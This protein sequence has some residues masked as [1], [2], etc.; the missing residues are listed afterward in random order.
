M[1][2]AYLQFQ[3]VLNDTEAN[4]K[5]IAELTGKI[6]ENIDL[7]IMPELTNSGYLFTSLDEAMSASEEIPGGKF[8]Q[9]LK[10]IASAKN[11]FIVSG[12]CE[13]AEDKLYNSAILVS[14]DGK[15][16]TYRKTHLF[17][18]E[19]LWFHQ[20]D[21]GLNVYE[22]AGEFGRVKI[23]MMICFD[24][25]FP[26][27]ARTLALKGAQIIAHPSNLVLGY[28]QQAMFTRAVENRVYTITA[29]RTGTEKNGDKELYFTGKSVIVDPKGNYLASGGVDS[30]EIKIVE[31]DPEL[32]LDKNIT[33]LNNIFEDSRTEFYR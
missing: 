2:A 30:E 28:C 14:P 31:I 4:I 24:W 13:R 6:T 8:C 15:I 7:L 25:V 33:K 12:I 9:T 11:M 17:Y 16:D 3:P 22:I 29:N 19:K 10:Q 1:K 32:A 21:S 23:G 20:G 5:Q 26:E 18:E 27:A